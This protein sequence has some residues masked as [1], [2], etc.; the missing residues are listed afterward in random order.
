MEESENT[1]ND[2]TDS[3]AELESAADTVAPVS[4]TPAETPAEP[5]L[6]PEPLPEKKKKKL[7]FL[8]KLLLFPFELLLF[9]LLLMLIWFT[10]A[11]FD[12]VKSVD[13][14]PPDYALYLRTDSVYDAVE[15]LLDLDATLIAMTGPELQKYRETYLEIKTSKLRKNFFVKKALQRRFDAAVYGSEEAV[16]A[17]EAEG[18]N[19]GHPMSAIGVLDAGLLSGALRLAPYVIPYI[20]PLASKLE[21]SSN[22]NGSFYKFEESGFFVIKKNLLIFSTDK[23]LLERAMTYSNSALYQEEALEAVN[24]RLREPL[25][26]LAHGNNLLKLL[27]SQPDNLAKNYLE[28]IVPYLSQEKYTSL[29]FGITDSELNVSIAVPMELAQSEVGDADAAEA[30]LEGSPEGELE[31]PVLR[32]LKRESKVPSLLPQFG[33]DVQY[34]TLLS[35]GSLSDLMDAAVKILPPEKNFSTTWSRADTT[36][37]ILFNRSLDEILFSW[38]GDEFAVFGIE[39]KSEPVF[40][41]KI[42]D[43]EKRREIFDRVFSSYIINS[44]DSLLVDGLRLPCMQLPAFIQSLLKIFNINVPKPYYFIKDEYIYFSQSPE[45]LVAINFGAQKSK[46][47]SGSQN[48]MRV[49]SRQSPYS[50]LSLY[51]NLERSVPFFIKGNSSMSKILSL[52]NSGRFDLRINDNTLTLQL[53]ASALELESS[54]H[55]PGFPIELENKSNYE[56]VSSNAKKS[57]QIFWLENGLSVNA[58]DCGSFNRLQFELPEAQYIVAASESTIKANGG[59]I[60]AVTKSGLVYLLNSKL[61][62]VLGYPILSGVS[63]TCPPFVYKDSLVLVS[64]DGEFCFISDKGQVSSL[65]IQIESEIKS[66]PIVSGDVIAFYEKGFFGGIH[67]YKNLQPVSS[68]GPFEMDGIAYGSPCIFTAG[69]KQ[70]A[71]MITQAGQLYVYDFEG[72]LLTPFPVSLEGLFYQNVEMADGYLFALSAEGELYRISLDGSC[73]KVKLPYFTARSG[74]ITV[75]DY[76]GKAGQEIF[77]SGDGNS[78]YGFN[79]MLELLPDFPVSGYGNPL[80]QDLNGDNKNDCIAITFDNKIAAANVLQSQK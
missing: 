30:E 47:L 75:Y 73:I 38:T 57:R 37:R 19:E 44:D 21:L 56:L 39:G 78:L 23:E 28:A 17:A 79:S 14:L 34:Y 16:F 59:E 46:K 53:Q 3:V 42:S 36:C 11:Y 60:W 32:L 33:E 8:V 10:F 76:D 25:R 9:L 69:G 71:A 13:A 27:T 64:N 70:Y 63:M 67:I 65:E 35:A 62:S 80:F 24:S 7:P 58:L 1:K 61:E 2:I 66:S 40:S 74:R 49:S 68:Q 15:P 18:E 43:E 29:T 31:H 5:S 41:F 6:E 45:N 12:K 55:I 52:Y 22:G 51:Y 72:Q 54:R 77:I 4:E 20:K 26:L 50:T 48:W